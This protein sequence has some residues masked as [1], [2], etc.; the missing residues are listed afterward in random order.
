VRTSL[1]AASVRSSACIS[2]LPVERSGPGP[3]ARALSGR[4][5]ARRGRAARGPCSSPPSTALTRRDPP[6]SSS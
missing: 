3:D 5:H 1:M 6:T 2:G 4:R